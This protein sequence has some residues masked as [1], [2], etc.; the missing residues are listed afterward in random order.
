MNFPPSDMCRCTNEEC[1]K[2]T[3]CLRAWH[4]NVNPGTP[5]AAFP[6]WPECRAYIND[7]NE[8]DEYDA[9]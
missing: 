5:Y 1:P 7:G 4:S 3:S 6:S 9:E 8:E 2:Q